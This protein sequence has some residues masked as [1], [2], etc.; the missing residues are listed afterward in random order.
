MVEEELPPVREHG[1]FRGAD[2]TSLYYEVRGEGKPLLF[3]YG[4][5]CRREHWR[6]Q[7]RVLARTHQVILF[8]Y[9]GHHASDRPLNDRNLTIEWC[10]KDV[11]CLLTHLGLSQVVCFGHSMG[12][13]VAAEAI[14]L[15]PERF[16]AAVFICGSVNN[17]FEHMFYTNRLTR[18]FRVYGLLCEWAPDLM[19]QVWRRVTTNQGMSYFMTSRFGFNPTHALPEDVLGYM[20]GVANTPLPVFYSLLNDYTR[21]DGRAALKGVPCPV[22]MIAGE[23]DFITPLA[24]QEKMAK[25]LAHGEL[26]AIPYG[27]HNAHTDFPD[28]VNGYIRDFLKR[29]DY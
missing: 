9:R 17:P 3:C 5:T 21:F 10:A 1:F 29:I 4:L 26:K 23:R 13:A 8:D 28:K 7:V 20:R 2:G 15:Q 16:R 22:L 25:L 14:R 12:V 19:A 18:F 27:S 6:H 11:G 24:V